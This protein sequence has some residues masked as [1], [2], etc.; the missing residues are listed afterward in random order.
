MTGSLVYSESELNSIRLELD[1]IEKGV[2][3][4]QCL[5]GNSLFS[6]KWSIQG[7]DPEILSTHGKGRT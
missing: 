7:I 5:K 1:G 2:Y 3:V 4:V 6:E